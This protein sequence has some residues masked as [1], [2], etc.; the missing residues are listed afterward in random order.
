VGREV[1]MIELKKDINE[2]RERLGE[3]A[4]YP[5][6]FEQKVGNTDG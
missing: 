5:L 3:P 4:R 2:L 1:R 6:D